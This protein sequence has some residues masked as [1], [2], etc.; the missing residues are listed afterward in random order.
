MRI[1]FLAILA[2]I[3]ILTCCKQTVRNDL[4]LVETGETFSL[5]EKYVPAKKDSMKL[6]T[7]SL[8]FIG[9]QKKKPESFINEELPK[10][11]TDRSFFTKLSASTYNLASVPGY[12]V[13]FDTSKKVY[14]RKTLKPLIKNN[15]VP[16]SDAIN[17]GILYSNKI[18]KNASFNASAIIGGLKVENKQMM[19][20][21]VQDIVISYVPDSLVDCAAIKQIVENQIPVD[22][23]KFYFYVKNSTLTIIN[24]RVLK[25]TSFNV[26]VNSTYVT[27][28]GKIYN[29]NDKF[30]RERMVSVELISLDNLIDCQ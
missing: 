21:V 7:D 28:E 4:K 1:K 25:E 8:A 17:D 24:N 12:I 3:L 20:L 27:A 22:Q 5:I 2:C 29:S 18:N 14:E 19:E 11:Y 13:K 26:N 10:S 15:K 9:I 23:R 30:S 6:Q 16:I